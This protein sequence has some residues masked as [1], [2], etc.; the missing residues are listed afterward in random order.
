MDIEFHYYMMYLVAATAGFGPDDAYKIAYAS[1]YVDDNDMKL[2][3]DK[4]KS[5]AYHNYISQTMN[6]LNPKSTL[7]RIYP[8]FHFVPGDPMSKKAFRKDGKM[9]WLNTT[10]DSKNANKI[11]DA[12][13]ETE[14]LYR[15]GVACHGY[16][17]TWAHQNF[18]GYYDGFNAMAS[19]LGQLTP[20]IGHADAQHNPDW[21]ALV[22]RDERL[23]EERREN[24]SLFLDA[25]GLILQ[26]LIKFVDSKITKKRITQK[27]NELVKDLGKAIG[28]RDQSNS[29]QSER[30]AR[31]RELSTQTDYGAAEIPEYDCDKWLDAALDENVRGL[32]D[33]SDF[34]L[35]R[36]DPLRDVYSWADRKTY[37]QSDW[38][39]FQEAVKGHQDSA[40]EILSATN[41]KGLQLPQF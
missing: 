2:E 29:Y 3:I 15:I 35:A 11:M 39:Q 23:L 36:W 17:D 18:V 37:K 20:D 24:K 6:I 40:W 8:F 33:R 19:P 30:I 41:L 34:T 26:K 13:I 38:Y 10:P 12:A 28:D 16:V 7:F 31:Y 25:A 14:N 4:D 5:T 9:H 1:Q 32:R 22:W 27:K 21:P